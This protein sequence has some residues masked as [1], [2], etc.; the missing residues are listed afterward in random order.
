M[1]V[2]GVLVLGLVLQAEARSC[3]YTPCYFQCTK[4][5]FPETCARICDCEPVDDAKQNHFPN[6]GNRSAAL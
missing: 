2:M 3:R 6:S 1:V 5:R 4:G